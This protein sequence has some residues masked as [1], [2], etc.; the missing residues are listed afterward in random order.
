MPKVIQNA[1]FFFF[2]K[3]GSEG[4]RGVGNDNDVFSFEKDGG[5]QLV[6]TMNG[7]GLMTRQVLAKFLALH[8]HFFM[9]GLGWDYRRLA[10]LCFFY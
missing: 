8:N 7:E 3:G 9:Q 1:I 4:K 6:K 10:T 2:L 5:M